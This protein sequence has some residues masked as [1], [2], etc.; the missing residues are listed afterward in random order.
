MENE[1]AFA[2]FEIHVDAP[3]IDHHGKHVLPEVR[4]MWVLFGIAMLIVFQ[5]QL[6]IGFGMQE[7][8]ALSQEGEQIEEPFPETVHQEHAMSHVSVQKR[9]SART[10]SYQWMM[11][12]PTITN[13][14]VQ[15]LELAPGFLQAIC[16]PQ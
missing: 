2:C 15:M 13:M 3:G 6:G 16:F 9:S 8:R 14:V 1:K 7:G 10:R 4:R 11:K 12:K 5:M